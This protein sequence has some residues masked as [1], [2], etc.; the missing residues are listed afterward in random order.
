MQPMD[1]IKQYIKT[2]DEQ[3][4]KECRAAFK[5]LVETASKQKDV[6]CYPRVQIIDG[7]RVVDVV[8]MRRIGLNKDR[9]IKDRPL[10]AHVKIGKACDKLLSDIGYD[11]VSKRMYCPEFRLYKKR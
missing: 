4:V 11:F 2:G 3:L 5:L 1:V 9:S 7:Q 6:R 10:L 8:I